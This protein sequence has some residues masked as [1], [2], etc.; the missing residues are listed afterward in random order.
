M[1]QIWFGSMENEIYNPPRYFLHQ[2][3]DEWITDELSRRMIQDVDQSTVVGPRLI[4]SPV[5]GAISP[6]ELS[7]GVQTLILMA[8]DESGKVFNASACGDNCAKW[9]LK[10]AET[11]DLTI[12]LH[13]IMKFDSEPFKIRILNNG[14]IVQSFREYV[15]EAVLLI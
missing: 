6:R 4:D 1:L 9:I 2:Y 10:I 5:L 12:T 7:G 13:N 3:E 11:K 15:N 14:R 8:F